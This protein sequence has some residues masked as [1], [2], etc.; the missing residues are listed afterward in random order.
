MRNIK[1]IEMTGNPSA[2]SYSATVPAE[3]IDPG[4]DFMYFIEVMDKAG[5][6]I[7]YPDLEK[8]TPYIIV[9]LQRD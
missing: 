2:G 5:N 8:E 1:T 9:R 6:G 4:W 3:D 7:I